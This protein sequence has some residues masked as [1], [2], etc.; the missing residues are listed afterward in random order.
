DAADGEVER[1]GAKVDRAQGAILRH[2]RSMP[3]ANNAFAPLARALS[4]DP[5]QGPGED[6]Y[7]LW[8]RYRKLPAGVAARVRVRSIVVPARASVTLLAAAA[9]LTRGLE[10]MLGRAPAIRRA[11]GEGAL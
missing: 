5:S 2:L 1:V 11:A 6:G 3:S 10:G 9:E 4:V 8:L 7:D